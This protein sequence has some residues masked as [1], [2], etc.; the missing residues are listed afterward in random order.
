MQRG[1]LSWLGLILLVNLVQ[2]TESRAFPSAIGHGYTSCLNCHFNPQG[3]GALTDYGRAVG[4]T[5]F[6]AVPF[7]AKKPG[8]S[9]EEVDEFLGQTSGF[10]GSTQLPAWFRPAFNY[11]GLHLAQN[12]TED[13]PVSRFI[14]MQVDATVVLKTRG[15]KMVAVGR[16]GYYPVPENV[17]PAQ[18]P[19]AKSLISREHYVGTR[20]ARKFGVYA[21]M[22]DTAFG[23]RVPDHNAFLRSKTLLNQNDQSHGLLLH[24][25]GESSDVAVQVLAGNLYQAPELRMQGVSVMAER[26]W[27][28]DSRWGVSGYSANNEYRSRE[29]GAVHTRLGFGGHSSL[30]GQVGLI[31]NRPEGFDPELGG[32]FFGQ[33]QAPIARG[34]N[35]LVTTEFYTANIG[36]EGERRYRAGPSLQ[37]IPAQRLELRVDL[38]G[39][40]NTGSSTLSPDSFTLQS[41][42]HVWL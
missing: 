37:Y 23:I 16:L 29:M 34:L 24:Y 35:T 14:T 20:I 41:Q 9:A 27:G 13:E 18:R 31:R 7:Y 3:S 17:P 36:A 38:L 32:Y 2:V 8:R 40:R 1:T 25:G 28:R 15:D 19:V 12:L 4:A 6:A 11:R 30:L 5:A 21:G 39:S 10:L 22:M 26:D 33:Y 42:V